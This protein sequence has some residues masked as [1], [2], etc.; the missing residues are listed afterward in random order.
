MTRSG[1]PAEQAAAQARCQ[2]A[3]PE[4]EAA[5]CCQHPEPCGSRYS[6]GE[7]ARNSVTGSLSKTFAIRSATSR[8][9]FL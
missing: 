3:T 2:T 7:L 6:D 5:L 9:G 1:S 8:L 4:R